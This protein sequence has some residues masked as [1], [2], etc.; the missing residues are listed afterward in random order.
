[1]M[2]IELDDEVPPPS[3]PARSRLGR[4]TGR[5]L[6]VGVVVLALA[7][8]AAQWAAD[9]RA[10]TSWNRLSDRTNVV[11][12]VGRS[13]SVLWSP[14]VSDVLAIGRGAA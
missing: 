5:R 12:P 14:D 13:L 7:L 3:P 10:Q 9:A 8:I 11:L 6:A 2:P 4:R 1:M